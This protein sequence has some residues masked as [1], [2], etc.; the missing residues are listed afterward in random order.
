MNI[1]WHN[2]LRSEESVMKL[3]SYRLDLKFISKKSK[4]QICHEKLAPHAEEPN[5]AKQ[6]V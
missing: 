5:V 4:L 3:Y 1:G 6:L 2:A